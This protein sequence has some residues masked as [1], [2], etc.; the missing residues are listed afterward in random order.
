VR[1]F[2][3]QLVTDVDFVDGDSIS[4]DVAKN[5]EQDLMTEIQRAVE[6]FSL[7]TIRGH[8]IGKLQVAEIKSLVS[9]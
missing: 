7:R 3:T 6:R 4:D 8:K 5:Y 1:S 2:M 9:L